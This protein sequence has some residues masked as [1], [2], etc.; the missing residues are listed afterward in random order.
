[1]DIEAIKQ[2]AEDYKTKY[3]KATQEAE[4][5]LKDRLLHMKTQD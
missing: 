3:E 4:E 5:R 2:A 1:M